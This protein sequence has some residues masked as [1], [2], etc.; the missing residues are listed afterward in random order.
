MAK[1]KHMSSKED[2]DDHLL[3]MKQYYKRCQENNI[4]VQ[5]FF[6][7][8]DNNLLYICQDRVNITQ[9]LALNEY[10]E[11]TRLVEDKRIFKLV[12]D[13]C[14]MKDEVFA[15]ILDGCYKQ[16]QFNQKGEIEV[17]YL[18]TIVYNQGEFGPHTLKILK[19]LTPNLIEISFNNIS[20]S[21]GFNSKV[22]LSAIETIAKEGK[23]LM[24]LRISNVFMNN[25]PIVDGLCE[26]IKNCDVLT[27][28]DFSWSSIP[29]SKLVDL[30]EALMDRVYTMRS[31]DFSYNKLA[32]EDLSDEDNY[33][34]EFIDKMCEF[35]EEALVINHLKLSGMFSLRIRDQ[36][37]KILK[38]A[39]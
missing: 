28:I 2:D 38:K 8:F 21:G 16:C 29:T 4:I 3:A 39:I 10:L 31:I 36:L 32:P 1:K 5:P 19:K 26:I 9:A 12:I 7:T 6:L 23:M 35:L 37:Y 20:E 14:L 11:N 15:E 27:T 22:L 13:Q 33:V 18:T 17:Q 34:V 24:K 30:A 25:Q